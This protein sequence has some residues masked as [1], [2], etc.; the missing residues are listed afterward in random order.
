MAWNKEMLYCHCFSTFALEY[1][2]RRVQ[3][4]PSGLNLNGT[5]LFLAYADDVN[6]VEANVD[7]IRKTTE[8]LLDATKEVR[9]EAD[10]EK[11]K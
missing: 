6:I 1:A 10:P 11:T 7:S 5:H 4:N 2:I 9:L 8:A 3:E